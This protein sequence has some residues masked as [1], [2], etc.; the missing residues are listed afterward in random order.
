MKAPATE[1]RR[2][3]FVEIPPAHDGQQRQADI[4]LEPGSATE[5]MRHIPV[6]VDVVR[7]PLH[8][9]R[10]GYGGWKWVPLIE[11]AR[12]FVAY[13]FCASNFAGHARV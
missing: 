13:G 2:S 10:K 4:D 12:D 7:G 5:G 6:R 1:Q 8:G 11:D 3:P 9:D